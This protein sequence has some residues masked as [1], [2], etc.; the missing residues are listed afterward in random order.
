MGV[1]SNIVTILNPTIP[2]DQSIYETSDVAKA[3]LGTRLDVADRTFRYAKAAAASDLV[4][5]RVAVCAA[6][7]TGLGTVNLSIASTNIGATV[8]TCTSTS[9]STANLWAEGYFFVA[10]LTGEGHMYRIKGNSAGSTGFTVTLYDGLIAALGSASKVGISPNPYSGVTL[11]ATGKPMGV[12]PIAVT[13]SYYF[14]LQTKGL[15]NVIHQ[16]ADAAFS[17]LRISATA[18][19]LEA[20]ATGTLAATGNMYNI[21]AQ[22]QGLVSVDTECSPVFINFEN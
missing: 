18:G 10:D 17:P 12:N 7:S 4:A 21:V 8:I 15:A 16:A 9:L 19:G 5:G 22:N 20:V 11:T 14:W 3:R 2:V 1:P 13:S 6:A